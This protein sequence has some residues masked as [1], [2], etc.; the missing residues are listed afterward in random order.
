MANPSKNVN[1]LD[2]PRYVRGIRPALPESLP[3]YVEDELEKIQNSVDNLAYEADENSTAKVST[4]TIT[5]ITEDEALASR[6][7]TVE[8]TFTTEDAALSARITT[9]ETARVNADS[10]LATRT[11]TL[12]TN[13]NH[14]STG[15]SAAHARVTTEE[16]ARASADSALAS[17]TTTLETN[18]NHATTGLS[19]AHSRVSTEET[20]RADGDSALATRTTTLETNV[21]HATTGLS[22]AHS[23]VTT[24]ETARANGDSAL[25]TRTTTLESSVNHASTGLSAA[26][27]RI[28][29]EESARASGD[30]ALTTRVDTVEATANAKNRTFWQTTAPTAQAVGDL[31]FDTDDNNKP[32]RWN[33]TSWELAA[34]ARIAAN[35]ASIT[36]EQTAR[37][38]ADT[39]LASDI[40][41][42]ST[43][44]DGHTSTINTHAT[45]INGLNA[46]YGVSLNVNGHV[47]GFSQNNS[48][49]TSDFIIAADKF[50]IVAPSG[51]A[52]QAPFTVTAGQVEING[53]L[54]VNGTIV[55][56]K[57]GD[58][59]VSTGKVA[60]DAITKISY[61]ED[62]GVIA[63]ASGNNTWMSQSVVKAEALSS[64]KL[65]CQL[66]LTGP[67]AIDANIY[68]Q[69]M[70]STGVTLIAEKLLQVQFDANGTT[71]YPVSGS[72]FF[73][74]L[75]AATYV[76]RVILN[77][78]SAK[79]CSSLGTSHLEVMEIKR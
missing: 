59:S 78:F 5:R 18:V 50:Q 33:G 26:H 51:G 8:A 35:T 72:A 11:T 76:T 74:G 48:G 27:S 54:I 23:R 71:N 37:A 38:D 3:T 69:V 43:T 6:I 10:A 56:S 25:S 62:S 53:N 13:V 49:T 67:D 20:A 70:D 44:V 39:A 79:T 75:A 52:G 32:Y 36:T 46:R 31:W 19:A 42:V 14:V 65:T 16:S 24:E 45:S 29:T 22:A 12:E 41:T 66:G 40:S 64:L 28:T 21:N 17:R 2:Y 47:S 1:P 15:L 30:G 77:R 55:S 60:S 63:F 68:L 7:D 9:E 4:E 57:L 34:D 58:G 61:V 73:S